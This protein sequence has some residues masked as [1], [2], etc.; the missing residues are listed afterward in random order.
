MG[1]RWGWGGVGPGPGGAA[2]ARAWPWAWAWLWPWAWPRPGART[3]TALTVTGLQ[4]LAPPQ[5]HGALAYI[6]ANL[7][8]SFCERVNSAAKL[9]MTHDRTLLSDKHLEMLFFLQMNRD[10]IYY[11]KQRAS[12][13]GFGDGFGLFAWT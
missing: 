8:S 7:A 13:D 9:I 3:P 10:F 4:K 11:L 1:G 6:G 12:D 2:G 5:P